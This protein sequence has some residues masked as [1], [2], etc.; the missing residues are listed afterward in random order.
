MGAYRNG[1]IAVLALGGCGFGKADTT[2]RMAAA[3]VPKGGQVDAKTAENDAKGTI[4]EIYQS[5]GKGDTDGVMTLLAE[6]LVVFGPRRADATA[7]RAD[8]LVSLR[9]VIDAK[10]KTPLES[11]QLDVMPSPGGHSAWAFDVVDI[12]GEPV[13]V[14]A[15][16]SNS[17]DLWVVSAAAIAKTPAMK[18]VRHGLKSDAVVPPGMTGTAMVADAASGAV[19]KFQKGLADQATW[20]AELAARTDAVVIGP[21]TGDVTR[22]KAAIKK[23]W[24]KRVKA[25]T[26]E[27]AAGE[28]TAAATGDG[29]L[30]WVSA[31]IVKFSEE[32]DPLPLR[33]FAVYER[34]NGE[35]KMIALQEALALDQPGAGAAFKKIAA[36]ALPG[37]KEEAPK[38][39]PVKTA[40]HSKKKKKKAKPVSDSDS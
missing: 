30:A 20:G 40:K 25:G 27:V 29:Q 33:A 8:A 36:P 11:S 31:P 26:R 7:N 15:V 14:T 39:E 4:T 24:K 10:N 38:A 9:K 19:E 6:P 23:M 17:D 12:G 3:P 5:L 37:A 35:W 22:G 13:A 32:D 16:L 28:V 21:A 34:A 18:A 1:L 2:T